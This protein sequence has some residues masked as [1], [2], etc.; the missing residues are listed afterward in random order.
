[1][2]HH[3]YNFCLCVLPRVYAWVYVMVRA[4]H[5]GGLVL[6]DT[7]DTDTILSVQRSSGLPRLP[8]YRHGL[9]YA[10]IKRDTT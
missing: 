9:Q 3:F 6:P 4:T 5:W 8:Y 10:H 1:M 2:P 7:A